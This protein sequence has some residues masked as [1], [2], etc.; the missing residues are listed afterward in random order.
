MRFL[1]LNFFWG[2]Q[3]RRTRPPAERSSGLHSGFARGIY[4]VLL[5]FYWVRRGFTGFYW[6]SFGF[7][8][9]LPGFTELFLGLLGFT[10]LFL[11]LLGFMG[12][13]WVY[14][15]LQRVFLGFTEFYC[16]T[17]FYR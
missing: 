14:W 3:V 12:Y 8:G 6:A 5:G 11:G 16:F 2:L 9:V 1:F 4:Q 15:V 13:T 7:T 10:E 17:W